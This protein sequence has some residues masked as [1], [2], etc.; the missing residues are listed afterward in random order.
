MLRR[1][2]ATSAVPMPRR[3]RRAATGSRRTPGYRLPGSSSAPACSSLARQL[4]RPGLA[5]PGRSWLSAGALAPL[6]RRRRCSSRRWRGGARTQEQLL[7]WRP[8]CQLIFSV[9]QDG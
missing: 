4:Q 8:A 9:L 7:L 5:E 6:P 2:V 1:V 3:C